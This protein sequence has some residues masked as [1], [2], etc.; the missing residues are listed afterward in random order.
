MTGTN[1]ARVEGWWPINRPNCSVPETQTTA[2]GSSLL[3]LIYFPPPIAWQIT[4]MSFYDV[5]IIWPYSFGRKTTAH[6]QRKCHDLS[7]HLPALPLLKSQLLSLHPNC[8]VFSL[9]QISCL[10]IA[11]YQS[12]KWI[13]S[14]KVSDLLG[15]DL[16]VH[17]HWLQGHFWLIWLQLDMLVCLHAL[18]ILL[19]FQIIISLVLKLL[20]SCDTTI[21][22]QLAVW[23]AMQ[24]FGEVAAISQL[25]PASMWR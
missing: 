25:R 11:K 22:E 15:E 7:A 9:S 5:T 20:Y 12:M 19:M 16:Y 1:I 18:Y 23:S 14:S 2:P 17:L 13:R 10:Y 8:I 3:F 21:G 6:V 4:M 24:F